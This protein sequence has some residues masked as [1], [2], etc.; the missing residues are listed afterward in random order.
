MRDE[1]TLINNLFSDCMNEVLEDKN[2]EDLFQRLSTEPIGLFSIL[3]EE[4]PPT[5]DDI[6]K[7]LIE[8]EK[9]LDPKE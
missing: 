7:Y 5:C 3:N 8:P 9:L 2:T 6:T 1:D 4:N